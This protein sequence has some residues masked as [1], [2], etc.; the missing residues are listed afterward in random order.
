MIEAVLVTLARLIETAAPTLSGPPWVAV[1]PSA[2]AEPSTLAEE[3]SVSRPPELTV[4]PSGSEASAVALI[5][6]KVTAAAMPTVL[7]PPLPVPP[8][9]PVPAVGV[10]ESLEVL[11]PLLEAVLLAWPSWSLACPLAFSPL[12]PLELEES[13]L[14]PAT[15]ARVVPVLPAAMLALKVIAPPAETL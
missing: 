11:A 1:S 14:A 3:P 13:V 8:L 12:A 6:L 15:L 2:V 5:R 10:L 7:A 9:S 4:R